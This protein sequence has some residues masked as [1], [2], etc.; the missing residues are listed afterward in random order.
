[1]TARGAVADMTEPLIAP[2]A[3]LRPAPGRAGEVAAPPYDV[4]TTDEA[5]ARAAHRPWDFLHV[6]RPEIDLPAGADPHGDDAYAGAAAAF[7]RMQEEGV[8]IRDPKPAFYAYRITDGGHVQTGLAAAACVPAYA[9]GRIRRHE[10]TRPAKEQDRARQIAAVGAHTGP[11]FVVHRPNPVVSAALDAATA[12]AP[13]ADVA[14]DGIRHQ[15][16]AIG[17]AAAIAGLA[18]AFEAMARLYVAD[19]HH[20]AAA[21]VRVHAARPRADRFL[22]V[23]FP[24]DQVRILDY[25]R[26]VRDLKGMTAEAFV[27]AVRARF[28][29]EP[30]DHPVR[31]ERAGVFGMV[32][33]GRW[34]RLVSRSATG[35]TV[36][37]L[38]RLDVTRL[39]EDLLSPVLGIGDVR[40]DPRIDFVGGSRGLETLDSMVRSG[41]WAV[42]FSLY[43]TSLDDLMAVADAGEVM[44]P[45][46]TWFDPK[47]ADGLL[48]LPLD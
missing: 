14:L 46:S 47:L 15:V 33:A 37:P 23:S 8:L 44:P 16:W 11:V 10:L 45:K 17:T 42:A 1:M 22:V 4:V 43:P 12:R 21:A 48:S 27:E 26:V 3:A 39:A 28:D 32:V 38:A 19:G 36:G 30:R 2:F 29:V 40:T 6:S 5:R 18:Q 25:N 13:D 31:P 24:A 34:Y 20:R 9:G 35:G 41:D 7:R